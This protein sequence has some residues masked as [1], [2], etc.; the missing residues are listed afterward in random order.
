[1]V[2]GVR[3]TVEECKEKLP[4]G[5]VRTVVAQLHL[6]RWLLELKLPPEDQLEAEQII[7]WVQNQWMLENPDNFDEEV[8]LLLAHARIAAAGRTSPH[9]GN[10]AMYQQLQNTNGC[11][12]SFC[13]DEQT[14]LVRNLFW[15]SVYLW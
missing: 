8:A 10:K 12:G 4:L 5:D 6:A 15:P 11:L 3:Q 9:H 2:D 7:E 13:Q 14:C 1:L